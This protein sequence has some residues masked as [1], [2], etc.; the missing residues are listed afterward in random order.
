LTPLRVNEAVVHALGAAT[1]FAKAA[2]TQERR[3]Y[4]ERARRS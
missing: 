1:I 2:N 3:D 4:E